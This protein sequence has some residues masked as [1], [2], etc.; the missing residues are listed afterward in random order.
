MMTRSTDRPEGPPRLSYNTT[1]VLQALVSGH[2]YG[3][4]LMRITE[5]PSG[6]VYP[7]LARLRA[8]GLVR[9]R[10]EDEGEA[11]AQARPR[12]RYYEATPLGEAALR[13][14]IE[15]LAQQR[16]LFGD[17]LEAGTR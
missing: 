10:W 5:L 13:E 2:R 4:D 12:R 3:F 8:T 15:R 11:H 6:T 17:A 1:L 9:S 16:R 14:A 7:I